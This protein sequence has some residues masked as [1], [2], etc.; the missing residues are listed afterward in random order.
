MRAKHIYDD[1]DMQG[2]I[3]SFEKIT[4]YIP[5]ASKRNEHRF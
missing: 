4:L 1:D 2:I 3:Q 5:H